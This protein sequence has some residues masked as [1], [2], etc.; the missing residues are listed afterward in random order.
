MLINGLWMHWI[1]K[2]EQIHSCETFFWNNP[3]SFPALFTLLLSVW[4]FDIKSK[5]MVNDNRQLLERKSAYSYCW[6][7]LHKETLWLWLNNDSCFSSYASVILL[8][9]CTYRSIAQASLTFPSATTTIYF[10]TIIKSHKLEKVKNFTIK[11]KSLK[12]SV[13]QT[14][15]LREKLKF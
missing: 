1:W 2:V 8:G 9:S 11:W 7:K 10:I 12:K 6:P 4:S 5:I 14:K 15:L 13:K 3:Q